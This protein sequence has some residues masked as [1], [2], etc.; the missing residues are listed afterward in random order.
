MKAS[1]SFMSMSI[2]RAIDFAKASRNIALVPKIESFDFIEVL[3]SQIRCVNNLRVSSS[4][5]MVVLDLPFTT[6]EQNI[7]K[8][9]LSDK[10]WLEENMLCLLSNAV[11]YS[12]DNT[13]VKVLLSLERADTSYAVDPHTGKKVTAL[14]APLPTIT[15]AAA[16]TGHSARVVLNM[17]DEHSGD[18]C[19]D[20]GAAD[21]PVEPAGILG[22]VLSTMKYFQNQFTT[23]PVPSHNTL[24]ESTTTNTR[25]AIGD[26]EIMYIEPESFSIS[27]T[28]TGSGVDAAIAQNRSISGGCGAD[29]KRIG[30]T[31]SGV[32]RP[33]E[34]R[35]R[36]PG[37]S[38]HTSRPT[39]KRG[40]FSS[41]ALWTDMLRI[42]VEDSGPG[43]SEEAMEKLFHNQAVKQGQRFTGGTG[44]GLFSLAKRTEALGGRCGVHAR[45]DGKPGCVFWF[46]IPYRP[47][48]TVSDLDSSMLEERDAYIQSRHP[49]LIAA[50][51][52][53]RSSYE[54][55]LVLSPSSSVE[56]LGKVSDAAGVDLVGIDGDQSKR[57]AG[58][59]SSSNSPIQSHS[60][61]DGE[62]SLSQGESR[63]CDSQQR[64]PRTLRTPSSAS[65][66]GAPA[67]VPAATNG[68]RVL[69]VDDAPTILRMVSRT[70]EERGF[71]VDTAKNGAV[72]LE[73]MV[74]ANLALGAAHADSA[75]EPRATAT[76]T[77]T[78]DADAGVDRAY[79]VV[80]TDIQMPVM[81]KYSNL[82]SVLFLAF[83]RRFFFT[84]TPICC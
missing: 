22:G 19:D 41:A 73:K 61:S 50:D 15:A 67:A 13:S 51:L 1:C 71:I 29:G 54:L 69:V 60:N 7:R 27:G 4:A 30:P 36:T 80:L 39:S 56:G 75:A 40:S 34:A 58:K 53:P 64:F 62:C 3:K 24:Q 59:A 57:D 82:L 5:P 43:L 21:T 11:K 84:L 2:N 65:I 55:S 68:L 26:A 76:A 77:A 37:S 14:F 81:G 83:Y 44:L 25:A 70:L 49:S 8:V 66:I 38:R 42:T 79:D 63:P 20:G 46:A 74:R 6:I 78:A 9:V 52:S 35:K 72:A 31:G 28:G 10:Q 16:A 48:E 47:D 32:N 12:Q 45:D 33:R 17:P 23:V 18:E